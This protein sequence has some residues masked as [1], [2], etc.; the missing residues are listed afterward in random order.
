MTRGSAK[1]ASL[2]LVVALAMGLAS[3]AARAAPGPSPGALT[4]QAGPSQTPL[5]PTPYATPQPPLVPVL[6]APAAPSPAE[7][8][9][10]SEVVVQTG[11]HA[12]TAHARRGWRPPAATAEQLGL[13][14]QPGEAMDAAWVRRQFELNHLVGAA[15]TSD[16]VVALVL[17][18]NQAYAQSGYINSGVV[19]LR[20]DW[21]A[22][23]RLQLR[24]IS[25]RLGPGRQALTV[26][27][28]PGGRRGLRAK[29]IRDRLPSATRVPLNAADLEHDFRLLADNA[30]IETVNAQLVP[31]A[32]PGEASLALVVA[33]Q[34]R[35]DVYS[36]VANSRNPSVGPIRF[37][38]GGSL[39]NL[40]FSGDLVSVDVGQ[41]SGLTDAVV[42]YATPF[43]TPRLTADVQG[44]YDAAAVVDPTVA[45]LD[46]RSTETSVEGGLTAHLLAEPLTPMTSGQGWNPAQ[47]F[48]L[49]LRVA[50]RHSTSS[51]LGQPFSFSPGAV[52]G[53]TDLTV[54]RF[55][56]SY[57][58]RS[59]TS[60]MALS[61]TLSNGLAGTGS[62][63]VGVAKPDPHFFVALVQG[64]YAR[65]LVAGLELHARLTG[66]WSSSLLYAMERLS[67][68]GADTVRGYRENLL[69]ADTGAIGSLELACPLTVGKPFCGTTTDWTTVR[70]AVFAD[71]AYVHNRVAPQPAPGGIASVGVSGAWNPSAAFAARLTYGYGLVHVEESGP[72][73]LQDRGVSFSVTVHP[74]QLIP[75]L[76]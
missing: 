43:L 27:W 55:V 40:A 67:A 18:I 63:I 70:V 52:N 61:A 13:A 11:P 73:D 54:L 10:L 19:F 66:Q 36:G 71:G 25:G 31:G 72:R 47:T 2:G 15:T 42:D 35:V 3:G 4:P 39:R 12:G 9:T 46:I 23:G 65:K 26:T 16:R 69:L 7:G 38:A 37:F 24:L 75:A 6:P 74:L 56:A 1:R 17:L 20:Q 29:F 41:T 5:P 62:D 30:A 49:G 50:Q 28:G 32:A 33:P 59:Q 57:V 53:V 45:K 68:G 60:A 8:V 14:L 22:G 48:D 44:L 76:R 51:L 58:R 34:P 21:S 64:N